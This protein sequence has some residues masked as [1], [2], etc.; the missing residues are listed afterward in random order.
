[1]I[2][3]IVFDMGNVLI[4]YD[5]QRYI[6]DYVDNEADKELLY[7]EVFGSVEWIRRDHG[8]M[9]ESEAIESICK[10]LP[11]RLHQSVVTL[12]ENWHKDI[13]PFPEME[14]L[15]ERLKR[16]GYNIYL[17]SNTGDR[18][19]TFRKNI[20]ALRFFD[21]EFISCDWH[22]LKPDVAIFHTFCLHFGLNP[23]ECFFVDDSPA[24]IYGAQQAG[25][26]GFVYYRNTEALERALKE[27]GV[28]F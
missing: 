11:Q 12:F 3:N 17:L 21:G 15:I 14:S 9:T 20:P 25:M 7:Y 18:Y 6:K 4:L 2:K 16:A 13:P 28:R 5:A 19:Y 10:R 27:C 26:H 24:N 22:L 8:T 1:M 23:A